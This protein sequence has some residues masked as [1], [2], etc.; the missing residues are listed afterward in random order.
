[1]AFD[2]YTP[3]ELMKARE[4]NIKFTQ[5]FLRM[6]YPHIMTFKS[7]QVMLD[8][9]GGKV[10][11]AVY[12]SPSV[13]GQVSKT[14][15]YLTQSFEPGYAKPKHMVDMQS[16]LKRRA[17]EAIGGELSPSDRYD[18]LVSQNIEDEEKALQQLEEYQAVQMALY[19]KYTMYGTNL[20]EPIE[21]DTERNPA[22]HIVQ[23][24]AGRWSV[25][26]AALFDPTGD[27]DAYADLSS[28]TIDVIVMGGK[29]WAAINRFKAFRDKFDSRRGSV[30]LAEL[31][32]KDLGAWVS[33]K[34]SYGDTLIIVTKHKYIDPNDG[35]EKLYVPE[36]GMLLASQSAEGHRLYG[37]IQ[38]M[39]AI[40]E[41]MEEG[42][43]FPK[44]W[45][46]GGDPANYYTMT[47]S[48][49]AMVL[50]D[51]NQFVFIELN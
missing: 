45:K 26:D 51:A 48:A 36:N 39:D 34:G 19:G 18:F 35:T 17:G 40:H 42:D 31:G 10:G 47:Q 11:M 37:C 43:R 2:I 27:I 21:V 9:I 23:A 49:P 15:G 24:G 30:S 20:P 38:D 44:N 5:L 25:Q 29:A 3:A 6:F 41:G 28:G 12:C 22:N 13:S 1:M 16:T 33:I 7:K 46:E 50:P 4:E 8:K 14:R 32:L